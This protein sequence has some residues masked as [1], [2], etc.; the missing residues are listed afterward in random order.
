M[1]RIAR[2][3]TPIPVRCD[4]QLLSVDALHWRIGIALDAIRVSPLKSSGGVSGCREEEGFLPT[5]CNDPVNALH[6]TDADRSV[7]MLNLSDGVSRT[8]VDSAVCS[9]RSDPSVGVAVSPHPIASELF[10]LLPREP[11][12]P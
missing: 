6:L 12:T 5:R 3:L 11:V 7:V 2:Q 4:L 8:Y 10:G 1:E 9:G